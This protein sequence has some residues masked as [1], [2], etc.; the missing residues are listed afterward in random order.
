MSRPQGGA[1]R[2]VTGLI[3]GVDPGCCQ[4]GDAF[5]PETDLHATA[6]IAQ[7]CEAIFLRRSPQAASS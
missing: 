4:L 7:E 6:V 5:A 2:H 3:R 1:T